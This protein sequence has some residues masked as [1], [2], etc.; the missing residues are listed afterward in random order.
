VGGIFSAKD[1][2]E[3]LEAG[4]SLVQ[5]YS[6]MIYEGPNLIKEIKKG[7]QLYFAK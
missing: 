5:V 4:A 2:I 7:L 3:K 6:G 1:A